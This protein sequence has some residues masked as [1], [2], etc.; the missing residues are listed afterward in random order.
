MPKPVICDFAAYDMQLFQ[1]RQP[2]EVFQQGDG[3]LTGHAFVRLDAEAGQHLRQ[4]LPREEAF[5]LGRLWKAFKEAGWALMLPV[6][7]L[8]GIFGGIVTATEGAGLAVVAWWR[9]LN[10]KELARVAAEAFSSITGLD[11]TL[12]QLTGADLAADGGLAQV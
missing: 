3:I 10:G 11:L 1:R 12:A 2:V 4:D 8:G 7:I 9:L 5:D 6:I